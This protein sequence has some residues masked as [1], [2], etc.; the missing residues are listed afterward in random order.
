MAIFEFS[1]SNGYSSFNLVYECRFIPIIEIG[2]EIQSHFSYLVEVPCTGKTCCE[3]RG[4]EES[5]SRTS[6]N[7][8]L[9]CLTTFQG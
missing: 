4:Y 3:E 6:I 1:S 2:D 7:D 9:D 5:S 8:R